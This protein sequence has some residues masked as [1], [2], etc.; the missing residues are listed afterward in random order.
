MN[1]DTVLLIANA[2]VFGI[3]WTLAYYYIR[4]NLNPGATGAGAKNSVTAKLS[5]NAPLSIYWNDSMYGGIAMFFAF[6]VRKL[7]GDFLNSSL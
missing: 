5:G 7:I 2:L 3:T 6:I 1:R 4:K